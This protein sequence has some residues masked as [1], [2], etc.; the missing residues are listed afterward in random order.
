M[1]SYNNYKQDKTKKSD[2]EDHANAKSYDPL[3]DKRNELPKEDWERFISYYRKYPD[4]F[5]TEVLGLKIFLFQKLIL[6]AMARNQWVMLICCRG[7]SFASSYR[8]IR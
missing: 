4:K 2:Y 8:N 3:K 6:R 5:A 7:N 1:A